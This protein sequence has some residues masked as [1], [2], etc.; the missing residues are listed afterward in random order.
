MVTL[1][2][3]YEL[4]PRKLHGKP[5]SKQGQIGKSS[6]GLLS[7]KVV[8]FDGFRVDRLSSGVILSLDK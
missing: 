2:V 5:R 1:P 3:L 7:D 8:R 4:F 6:L